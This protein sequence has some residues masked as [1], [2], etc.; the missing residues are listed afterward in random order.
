MLGKEKKIEARGKDNI[1]SNM[2]FRYAPYWPLFVILM[3][4]GGVA[5]WYYVRHTAPLFEA[6]ATILIKDEKKGLDDSKMMESLNLLRTKKIIE[7]E[8]EVLHSRALMTAVVKNLHLYA[9]VE[10]KAEPIFGASYDY[11]PVMIE[12]TNPDSL[13]DASRVSFQLNLDKKQIS[14]DSK[15]F[16]LNEWVRTGY[17]K[18][19]FT[20]TGKPAS[21]QQLYFSITHPQKITQAL[22][23]RLSVVSANKLSTVIHLTIKDAVPKR[24][25]SILNELMKEYNKATLDDK[26]ILAVNTKLFV[27]DRLSFVT[28]ELD[29]IEQKIQQYKAR[30][31]VVDISA[32]GKLFLQNVSDNDQKLSDVNMQLAVLSQVE[33]YVSS[34]DNQTGIVPSTLG[35]NDEMLTQMVQKLYNAELDYVKLK[36][37]TAENN[38]LMVSL[39]DQIDRLRPSINEIIGNRKNNLEVSRQNIYSTNGKYTSLLNSIPEKERE[40]LE[41]SREQSIKNNIY[42]FLLQKREEA[43]LSQS[44]MVSDSRVVDTAQAS[45]APVSPNTKLIYG[46]AIISAFVLAA[47]LLAFK[48]IFSQTILFRSELEALTDLPVVSEIGYSKLTHPIVVSDKKGW[49]QAE[50]FRRIRALLPSLGIKHDKKRILVTSTLSNEG[51]SFVALNLANSLA[52]SGKK[53]VLV[54]FD[55]VRPV[56]QERLKESYEKGLSDYLEGNAMPDEIIKTSSWN[57]NLSIVYSGSIP[58]EPSELILKGNPEALLSHL[59]SS[60][61][62]VVLDVAPAGLTADALVLSPLCDLTFYLVRHK[63]TPKEVV[64]HLD[65]NNKLANLNNTVLLFNGVKQKG[66]WKR[67]A[68]YGYGY[69]HSYNA[70]YAV[71]AFKAANR[72]VALNG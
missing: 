17:G 1:L 23:G 32:Q 46:S 11:S 3:M 10:Q 55:L 26:N 59:N 28:K 15:T 13:V 5:A 56:L 18:L 19:R 12:S 66:I 36:K 8:I 71:P 24:A 53:V 51:K 62:Y 7:N 27:E 25:E 22:L 37:T 38:P 34:K 16:P 68:S 58:E 50:Q 21:E 61:D 60:F 54:E 30:K 48:E 33:K 65:E 9:T 6:S 70:T 14:F 44:S 69:G 45:G 31:G 20:S 52:L 47:L 4:I 40:L 2:W 41:I 57:N 42:S 64:R 29:S 39:T 35:L 67:K 72:G 63:Y 43:A 49:V